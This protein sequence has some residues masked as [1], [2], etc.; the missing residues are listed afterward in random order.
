MKDG[1]ENFSIKELIKINKLIV[2]MAEEK[3]LPLMLY[4]ADETEKLINKEGNVKKV[5]EKTIVINEKDKSKKEI[6]E[7]IK[8]KLKENLP[9]EIVDEILKCI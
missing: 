1:L 7:E 8:R 6:K 3:L 2:E 5:K 9:K 4:L